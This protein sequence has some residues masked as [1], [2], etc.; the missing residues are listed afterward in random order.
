MSNQENNM[1][2]GITQTQETPIVLPEQATIVA[3]AALAAEA[4]QVSVPTKSNR[5]RNFLL[6][7]GGVGGVI[8]LGFMF[9]NAGAESENIADSPVVEQPATTPSP[10]ATPSVSVTPEEQTPAVPKTAEELI[11]D[12]RQ[13]PSSV[14]EYGTFANLSEGQKDWMRQVNELS[15]EQFADLPREEQVAFGKQVFENML[16]KTQA[17]LREHGVVL[18]YT[19]NPQTSE[20]KVNNQLLHWVTAGWV[21]ERPNNDY[22]NPPIFNQT[23]SLAMVTLMREL[24]DDLMNSWSEQYNSFVDYSNRI[25]PSGLYKSALRTVVEESEVAGGDILVTVQD[26]TGNY[27]Q[28]IFGE[29]DVLAV[30]DAFN[31]TESPEVI[32]KNTYMKWSSTSA[33]YEP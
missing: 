8:G 3:S 5:K 24:N 19:E 7:S 30:P 16:I 21:Y 2:E 9:A 20:E 13:M 27:R 6:I 31:P 1:H 4:P 17:A 26:P 22:S 11:G 10:S 12:P 14:V 15:P 28:M 29:E 32:G 18:I 33:N 23:A 25:V